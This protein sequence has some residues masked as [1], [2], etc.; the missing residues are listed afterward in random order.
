MARDLF[1]KL[2]QKRHLV[3]VLASIAVIGVIGFLLVT[4]YCAQVNLQNSALD[5]FRQ[6][7]EKRAIAIGYFFAERKNDIKDLADDRIVSIFFENKSLGMSME[8]GLGASLAAFSA[9]FDRLR[10]ERKLGTDFI[11][12]R[13]AFVQPDGA[14]LADTAP[15]HDNKP[16][17]FTQQSQQPHTDDDVPIVFTNSDGDGRNLYV[18]TPYFLKNQYAGR[19]IAQIDDHVLREHFFR[20]SGNS[21][22]FVALMC[23]THPSDWVNHLPSTNRLAGLPTLADMQ[24]GIP[25]RCATTGPNGAKCSMLAIRVPVKGVPLSLVNIVPVSDVFGASPWRL[26]F[27]MATL[28]LTVLGSVAAGFRRNTRNLVL[29]AR[30]EEASLRQQ[31]TEAI[32]RRLQKEINDR[33]MAE[34][35]L[36]EASAEL[37]MRVQQRTAQLARA[38]ES[39]QEEIAERRRTQTELQFAKEAAEAANQAKSEFLANMSHE[40]RTPMTAI[41]GYTDLLHEGITCC[42]RCPDHHVCEQRTLHQQNS[43]TIQRNG[44]HLLQLIND[45]LDLSKIEAGKLSMERIQCSPIQLIA[46]VRSLMQVRAIDKKLDLKIEF[47]GSVPESILGDPTR[48]R[49]ILINLMSNAIKFTEQG[50]VRLVTRFIPASMSSQQVP[51]GP[52]MQFDVIDTGIGMSPDQ[53]HNLFQPFQQADTSTTRKFGGTGL[54]LAISK[55]LAEG[56]G[57]TII[58][59]SQWGQ[60]STFRLTIATGSLEG[61]PMVEQPGDAVRQPRTQKSEHKLLDG[62]LDGR[63][64]LAED[65]PDNQ[66]LIAHIL[67]KAGVEVDVVSN[68]QLALEKTLAAMDEGRPYGV[69]F[70]DM[71]MPVMDGYDATRTLRRNGYKGPIVALT[72]HAMAADR[73]KCLDAGC[74]DFATKPIDH[75]KL[76]EIVATY[77]NRCTPETARALSSASTK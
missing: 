27:V 25:L 7:T 48:L 32:N 19:I 20:Y 35:A 15:P 49:Q 47:V 56:M 65:S 26:L 42:D 12:T 11:Y 51:A 66:R 23:P 28:S 57:G 74:D 62:S 10:Q 39:L 40:I 61:V 60:G 31:E 59:E 73:Q 38:N 2:A 72:A 53:L 13:I 69:I 14:I 67:Q 9:R 68:G 55:R 1:S 8:Y 30:L 71:Q 3:A 34:A 54:G 70:M 16:D 50:S 44:Q 37:E 36:Q 33:I 22:R 24:P 43:Q 46:E 21:R 75:T 64:L 4:N 63:V 45:I 77:V 6:E 41:M 18:S 58:V 76:V 29:Q 5:Q 17:Y 52:M